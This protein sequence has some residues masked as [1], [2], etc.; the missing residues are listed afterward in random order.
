MCIKNPVNAH[1]LAIKS[2]R[3]DIL[4]SLEADVLNL[5]MSEE[6][7]R[8]RGSVNVHHMTVHEGGLHIQQG[9]SLSLF[10]GGKLVLHDKPLLNEHLLESLE[11]SCQIT[12]PGIENHGQITA[13]QGHLTLESPVLVNGDQG[14]ISGHQVTLQG[15][16]LLNEGVIGVDDLQLATETLLNRGRLAAHHLSGWLGKGRNQGD[17]L[18]YG[19]LDLEIRD[20]FTNMQDILST[21][22]ITL[23]M[24]G[25]LDNQGDIVSKGLLSLKGKGTLANHGTLQSG[26]EGLTLETNKA[27]NTRLIQAEGNLL[28]NP[29]EEWVNE[30]GG[31]VHALG[32]TEIKGKGTL[33]NRGNRL[34]EGHWLNPDL[35]G[36]GLTLEDALWF[37][38]FR[39]TVINEGSW[40]TQGRVSGNLH[41]LENRG[42]WRAGI[43]GLEIGTFLNQPT[44]LL[45]GGMVEAPGFWRVGKGTNHGIL[46]GKTLDIHVGEEFIQSPRGAV[47]GEDS[48][49]FD[50]E[51]SGHLSLAGE[52]LSDQSILIN[53]KEFNSTGHMSAPEITLGEKVNR[54]IQNKTGEWVFKTLCLLGSQTL[55][56]TEGWIQGDLLTGQGILTN[57]G[58][59]QFKKIHMTGGSLENKQGA[60]M[61]LGS[62]DLTLDDLLNNGDLTLGKLITA[63]IK[64]TRNGGSLLFSQSGTLQGDSFLNTGRIIG[65]ADLKVVMRQSLKQ[66]KK[67]HTAGRLLLQA[68]SLSDKSSSQTLSDQS[69]TLNVSHPFFSQGLW[70][71]TTSFDLQTPSWHHEGILESP[72]QTDIRLGRQHLTNTGTMTLTQLSLFMNPGCELINKKQMTLLGIQSLSPGIGISNT[73]KLQVQMAAQNTPTVLVMERQE[74]DITSALSLS[75]LQTGSFSG[76]N[77]K[78]TPG[79]LDREKGLIYPAP[80]TPLLPDLFLPKEYTKDP[81]DPVLWEEIRNYA[82]EMNSTIKRDSSLWKESVFI[83]DPLFYITRNALRGF[84]ADIHDNSRDY[85]PYAR[86]TLEEKIQDQAA[87]HLQEVGRLKLGLFCNASFQTMAGNQEALERG[88]FYQSWRRGHYF[89]PYEQYYQ[90]YGFIPIGKK[91]AEWDKDR[92]VTKK[93]VP[94]LIEQGLRF[95]KNTRQWFGTLSHP[96]ALTQNIKGNIAVSSPYGPLVYPLFA[97]ERLQGD[98]YLPKTFRNDNRNAYLYQEIARYIDENLDK[99]QDKEGTFLGLSRK[100]A[101]YHLDP[102]FYVTRQAVMFSD[103]K[104]KEDIAAEMQKAFAYH[105]FM[106]PL[107]TKDKKG[108]ITNV[109]TPRLLDKGFVLFRDNS[110]KWLHLSRL[111]ND[112]ELT[113]LGGTWYLDQLVNYKDGVIH[114]GTGTGLHYTNLRNNGILRAHD[115][116]LEV[117]GDDNARNLWRLQ[118]EDDLTFKLSDHMDASGFLKDYRKY[119]K[120]NGTLTIEAPWFH[121]VDPDTVLPYPLRIVTQDFLNVGKIKTPGMEV[122]GGGR[123]RNGLLSQQ[124]WG[125]LLSTDFMTIEMY[126]LDNEWGR[127]KSH[128]SMVLHALGGNIENG[129]LVKT[130]KTSLPTPYHLPYSRYSGQYE[131][132]SHLSD[133]IRG[134]DW[135]QG[136]GEN[137]IKVHHGNQAVIACNDTLTM[138]ADQGN[139]HNDYGNIYSARDLTLTH[140]KGHMRTLAGNLWTHG[141]ATITGQRW[142][143]ERTPGESYLY[144]T[145]CKGKKGAGSKQW[146][147]RIHL[148]TS[149]PSSVK[150]LGNLFLQVNDTLIDGSSLL[151]GGHIYNSGKNPLN[152]QALPSSFK[153]KASHGGKP[154]LVQAHQS[155]LIN[156]G[157]FSVE[158]YREVGGKPL[159]Q[160]IMIDLAEVAEAMMKGNPLIGYA[161]SSSRQPRITFDGETG[162]GEQS[163]LY[164]NAVMLNGQSPLVGRM[165]YMDAR[166]FQFVLMETLASYAGTLSLKSFQGL[167]WEGQ[168]RALFRQGQKIAQKKQGALTQKDLEGLGTS[169]LFLKRKQIAGIDYDVAQFVLGTQDRNPTGHG[170]TT[171]TAPSITIHADT[172]L[173]KNATLV[174]TQEGVTLNASQSSHMMGTL[175]G[176]KFV[177]HTAPLSILERPVDRW[178]EEVTER[179]TSSGMFSSTTTTTKRKI[180]RMEV[181][182]GGRML[183]GK[184][185]TLNIKAHDLFSIGSQLSAGKGGIQVETTG[186]FEDR[187]LIETIWDHYHA[188][189]HGS[190]GEGYSEE[191]YVSTEAIHP[192]LWKADGNIILHHQGQALYHASDLHSEAGDIEIIARGN[193]AFPGVKTTQ[194]ETPTLSISGT[195][196]EKTVG[197]RE[198]GYIA[199]VKAPH[200]RLTLQS[201]EG[202][203]TGVRPHILSQSTQMKAKKIDLMEEADFRKT[204]KREQQTFVV[205]STVDPGLR[206]VMD[207]A[208]TV[209]CPALGV[210]G[211]HFVSALI[212]NN[213]NLSDAFREATSQDALKSLGT[214]IASAMILKGMSLNAP[215]GGDFMDH[216]SYQM[217]KSLIEIGTK[218]VIYQDKI[219]DA[220]QDALTQGLINSIASYGAQSIG[221]AFDTGK[222][223]GDYLLHK[224]A[225]GLLGAAK[226]YAL[227]KSKEGALSGALGAVV[228][229]VVAEQMTDRAEVK[230]GVEKQ[231]LEEG[232][233]HDTD[234]INEEFRDRLQPT[235]DKTK[236]VAGMLALASGQKVDIALQTAANALEYNFINYAAGN[237]LETELEIIQENSEFDPSWGMERVG[238]EM[239]RNPL[240]AKEDLLD[241]GHITAQILNYPYGAITGVYEV[242]SG[243]V[244]GDYTGQHALFLAGIDLIP[245]KRI[246]DVLRKGGSKIGKALLKGDRIEIPPLNDKARQKMHGISSTD[247]PQNRVAYEKYLAEKRSELTREEVHSVQDID[248]KRFMEKRYKETDK[249]WGGGTGNAVRYEKATGQSVGGRKHSQKAEDSIPFLEKWLENHPSKLSIHPKDFQDKGI[250]PGSS[251]DRQ[252]AEQVLKELK[253]SLGLK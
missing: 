191:G 115:G 177:H 233:V 132:W 16:S 31:W 234:R 122:S 157:Q 34:Q 105:I 239:A 43:M 119:W 98:A 178:I 214:K 158:G 184:G 9:G 46:Q 72:G 20:H 202:N 118:S 99:S 135:V 210:V 63:Q 91:L 197:T 6:A 212:F 147:R 138:I 231:A 61:D 113:L 60:E 8:V 45:V 164:T 219:E 49:T 168:T 211:S 55:G 221:K 28:L 70:K 175:Y 126:S 236:L 180:E 227:D 48:L 56:L 223:T 148:D 252:I 51:G 19:S 14:L 127:L 237:I 40:M 201:L 38:A 87:R 74:Q 129:A 222:G 47:K 83:L 190:Y 238:Y 78:G 81:L 248:L 208:L 161:A 235:L 141:N 44:D 253:N 23:T 226:G 97:D 92:G 145:Y 25:H 165:P 172:S 207:A 18:G 66:E 24:A 76:I 229:E 149:D 53:V 4:T 243:Y 13:R 124:R 10:K 133:L 218:A 62:V 241:T 86:S 213:G 205:G 54:W 104:S 155:I 69:L 93:L 250:I 109:L 232:W 95:L 112:H 246:A 106:T 209:A 67:L 21:Q 130:T 230:R 170:N 32:L 80:W 102:L 203:I 220:L 100:H 163:D 167:T 150:I 128:G 143:A 152:L 90:D 199:S 166:V 162:A 240:Q 188:E 79:F 71:G 41:H 140:P 103:G 169:A 225:H 173:V 194:E 137:P 154:S 3:C 17:L 151:V 26:K 111:A 77:A 64:R 58:A 224:T 12:A 179:R 30:Q 50:G 37:H 181:L 139:I 176:E 65:Q 36:A 85:A 108:E 121:H 185:G 57:D 89:I 144:E 52:T 245:G 1:W 153:V 204:L 94:R 171:L 73:G 35:E 183:T 182:T 96:Y 136:W 186:H 195:K 7:C 189:K 146:E 5:A 249:I 216:L 42:Y 244:R 125:E 142:S 242:G 22:Q 187:R 134:G 27:V 247:V 215:V 15:D 156:A 101:L 68:P 192:S 33:I 198:R 196:I 29:G 174:A 39:G 200:G 193:L 160:T 116:G 84:L 228:A 251:H 2:A 123:F 120:L 217:Q 131:H 107:Y 110:L 206:M 114:T 117:E 75:R 88:G 11:G 82:S 159:T 59:L